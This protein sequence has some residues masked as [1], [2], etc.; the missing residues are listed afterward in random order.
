[1]TTPDLTSLCAGRR[2]LVAGGTGFV[3]SHF[4]EALVRAGAHV[5]ATRHVRPPL[6]DDPRIDWVEADLMDRGQCLAA[7]QGMDWVIPA[8]GSVGS[9]GSDPARALAGMTDTLTLTGNLLWAAWNAKCQRI[10]V[11][12]SS[13][14]YP[15]SDHAM[16]ETE[17][18]DG[19]VHPSYDGYGWMRRYVER[20]ALFTARQSGL[21]VAIVRPGA[22]YGRHDNFD[23]AGSHVIAAL[24]RRAATRET[25]FVV[26]GTGDETRDILHVSDFAA[27]CLL[28]L[29]K[30]TSC[31]PVNIGAGQPTTIR[32]LAQHVLTAAGH[33][34]AL[35]FDP[36]KPGT[37]AHR[38]LDIGKAAA[39]GFSPAIPLPTG[40]ADTIAWLR[41]THPCR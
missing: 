13:T 24:I 1:M 40:L 21:H 4:I 23:P 9:A 16:A 41:K 28:V 36:S 31:D 2:V 35:V 26:W 33:T 38:R 27:G 3:G 8:A 22:I 39:L 17:F 37:I 7:A 18:W 15:D 34:A 32:A 10:L 30:G 29:A 12:S 25:P 5:R 19:P 11:F 14:G 20:L 6:V